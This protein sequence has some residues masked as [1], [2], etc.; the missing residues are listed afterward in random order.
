M[1]NFTF[2]LVKY[3]GRKSLYKM[4]LFGSKNLLFTRHLLNHIQNNFEH[5]SELLIRCLFWCITSSLFWRYVS[6]YLLSLSYPLVITLIGYFAVVQNYFVNFF[7]SSQATHEFNTMHNIF[8]TIFF[9]L[10]KWLHLICSTPQTTSQTPV[11]EG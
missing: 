7:M 8:K 2:V 1:C 4:L 11:S 9:K 10:E 5:C 3:I 6:W